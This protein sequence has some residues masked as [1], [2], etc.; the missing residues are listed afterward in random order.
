MLS[1]KKERDETTNFK[2]EKE[3]TQTKESRD[4]KKP[5]KQNNEIKNYTVSILIP[6]SIVDNAQVNNF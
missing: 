2:T 6:S 1:K 5:K 3:A 4:T